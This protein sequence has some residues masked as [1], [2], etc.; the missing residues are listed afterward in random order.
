MKFSLFFFDGDGAI[1]RPDQY[2]LLVDCAKFADE[3]DLTAIWTPERHFHAFGGLYPNPSLTSAALSLVTKNIQL[4]AGSVVLPLH[5]PVRVAEDWA[6]IDNLSGGRAAI[7]VASGWTMDEFI[8]SR[9]PHG[10]RRSI[11]WRNLELIQRLWRGESVDFEDA[12]GRSISVK[13]LPRPVSPE[14]P[15]WVTCQSTE[16]FI[17]AG[18]IGGNI[19]TS[20]L[21][22]TLD[23][24]LANIVKYRE[25]L[26]NN[27]HDPNSGTVSLMLHTFLGEDETNVKMDIRKPFGEY[28]KTHYGLLE[29]L[30]KGM[31]IDVSMDDFSDDDLD[32]ILE[33]GVEGFMNDRSLIGT[34]KGCCEFVEKIS[35]AGVDELCCLIDFV[36]DYQSVM[37]SLPFVKQLSELSA[38]A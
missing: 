10:A 18:R 9:N 14:L 15:I 3:S 25:S 31:G 11:M 2:R 17:E 6:V 24:T 37:N 29:N 36:Q 28:L 13:S 1:A 35:E 33:F 4:R 16:S 21:N 19:L 5:H 7:A 26:A 22:G 32:A 27:G 23:D 20:L 8:L 38:D 12:T 34:P 30:A